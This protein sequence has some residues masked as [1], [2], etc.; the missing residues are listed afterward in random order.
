MRVVLFL[1]VFLNTLFA[2]NYFDAQ[3]IKSN[4]NINYKNIKEI[5]GFEKVSFPFSLK[6]DPEDYWVKL[7]INKGLFLQSGELLK[8]TSM[9]GINEI[10]IDPS[11]EKHFIDENVFEIKDD[12]PNVIYFK[13]VNIQNNINVDVGIEDKISYFKEK[14]LK[15]KLY[16]IS[17][18]LVFAAFLYYM[19]FFVF[20]RKKS[21]LYYSLTQLFIFGLLILSQQSNYL[22]Y[23]FVSSGFVIFS[24]LFAQEFLQTKKYLPIIHKIFNFMIVLFLLDTFYLIS[25]YF[26]LSFFLLLYPISGIMSYYKTREKQILLYIFAWGLVVFS[27][28]FI[29]IEVYIEKIITF[30]LDLVDFLHI[31]LP[32]ESIILAF[33]LSY[34]M[35]LNE[36]AKIEKEKLLVH[37]NKLASLGEM[38]SNIA[39]QWRQP[40]TH[41]NYVFMNLNKAYEHNKLDESYL[42]NKTLEATDQLKYMSN[43]ID[44]F[45]DFY[46]PKTKKSQISVKEEIS[47]TLQIISATLKKEK[48]AIK[49]KGDDFI[50]Y[51]FKGE[52]SQVFL[53]LI[54]NAKDALINKNIE[55]AFINISLENKKLIISDNA[56]GIDDKL[57]DDIF[58]AYFTTKKEGNGIGLYMSKLIIEDHFKGKIIYQKK[59]NMSFFII[60][61]NIKNNS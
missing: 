55:D 27:I 20:N 5:K 29:T 3:I 18:G 11:L 26:P 31:I 57:I 58:K 2:D 43:T 46:T 25:Q 8:I 44:V 39:H 48:V 30:E 47:N 38:I 6:Q 12:F 34:S 9:F 54:T 7:N 49:I 19:L 59:N 51:G 10:K 41:L 33:A 28:A 37:Q 40:L 53:N 61:L 23:D 21:F 24:I 15:N 1:V 45:K 56:G 42:K 36:E 14:I 17:Q 4:P 35:K 22:P 16:G 52:L 32:L 13:I 60:D 50:V